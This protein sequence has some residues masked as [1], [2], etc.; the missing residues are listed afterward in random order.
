[1]RPEGVIGRCRPPGP[2]RQ[3]ESLPETNLHA[4]AAIV[5]YFDELADATV[6]GDVHSDRLSEIALGYSMEVIGPVPEG[7][8]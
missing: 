8:L 5:G 3:A 6:A 7:Y 4:R 1:M 2:N